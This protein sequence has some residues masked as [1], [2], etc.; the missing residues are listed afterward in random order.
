LWCYAE[1]ARLV[2][3]VAGGDVPR[4]STWF[5]IGR[6]LMNDASNGSFS[7]ARVLLV[8]VPIGL[9]FWAAKMYSGNLQTSAQTQLE[10]TMATRL[11]GDQ[12]P[13]KLDKK[14]TD[15]DGDL[16]AD[17]P[18]DAAQCIDPKEINLS[19]IAS[20]TGDEDESTWKE[21]MTAL[22]KKLDRKVNFISYA[23]RDEQM[24][25]LEKGDLH[26]TGFSTGEVPSAVNEAGFVP[27][28][29]FADKDGNFQ[30]TMKII[31]PADS[32]IKAVNDLKGKTLIFVR[33]Q[34]NSG[35]TVPLVTLMKEFHL[36]PERDY[37]WGFSYGHDISIKRIAEKQS[38]AAAVASD[39]LQRMVAEGA[40]PDD[41][42]RAIYESKR[43]PSGVIGYVYNLTPQ[44]RD[45]IREVL[46]GFDWKG[47]GLEKTFGKSGYVKFV[48]V[49]YKKD[50]EPVREI[51]KTGSQLFA[52]IDNKSI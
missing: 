24:R 31:V 15:A 36:Q 37:N 12:G 47:T 52:K 20:G 19:Y 23:D 43:Y 26:V 4:F 39:Y 6:S 25:A 40:V 2:S 22:E 42:V 48:P 28:A 34:S 11:L 33:P 50:W 17:P 29:C 16:V 46:L 13:E 44:L 9:I 41:A 5:A 1:P 27:V 14:F 49:E 3:G 8:V 18:K 7:I 30:Y 21:L 51:S 38:T 10:R 35:C 45:G 32:D